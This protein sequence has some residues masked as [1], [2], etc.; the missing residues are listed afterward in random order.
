V[1]SGSGTKGVH[2]G[3]TASPAGIGGAIAPLS[4]LGGDRKNSAGDLVVHDLKERMKRQR[5]G[6]VR[7]V[8]QV[9]GWWISKIWGVWQMGTTI[10]YI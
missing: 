8:R 6:W 9:L 4:P 5:E 2:R 1:T 3:K 10:T 7:W